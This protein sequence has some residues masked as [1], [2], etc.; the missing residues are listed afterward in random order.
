MEKKHKSVTIP[1][2]VYK[3]AK[4]MAEEQNRSLSN[5]IATLIIES[6]GK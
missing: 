5:L 1:A 3:L 4:Q 2:K 6:Y